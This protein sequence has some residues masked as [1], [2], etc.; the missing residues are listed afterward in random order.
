MGKNLWSFP[1]R[2]NMSREEIEKMESQHPCQELL[3]ALVSNLT[4]LKWKEKKIRKEKPDLLV[5]IPQ[6]MEDDIKYQRK[7]MKIYKGLKKKNVF[8]S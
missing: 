7:L 8:D 3:D 2:N 1:G 6:L 5:I 4:L